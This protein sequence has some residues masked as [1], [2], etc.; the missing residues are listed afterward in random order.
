MTR[1]ILAIDFGVRR[2]GL[3]ISDALGATA[4]GLGTLERTRIADDFAH[5]GKLVDQYAPR[6]VLIGNPISNSGGETAMSRRV[7]EFAA[8]LRSRLGCRV[9]LWDERGTSV[10]A[11]RVLRESGIGIGKRRQAADRVAAVL[12]LQSY[13]DYD[14]NER[15]RNQATEAESADSG[16]AE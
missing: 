6:L 3:A 11:N 2:C 12:L 15:A 13:L 7:A 1:R 14:A 4:Q 9:E 16:A 10:E 8:K 5:I